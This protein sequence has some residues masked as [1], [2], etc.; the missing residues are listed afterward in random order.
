[1]IAKERDFIPV[2]CGCFDVQ[3]NLDAKAFIHGHN[4]KCKS[5]GFKTHSI[6]LRLHFVENKY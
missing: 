5:K 3:V 6:K 1:M 2:R 4:Q